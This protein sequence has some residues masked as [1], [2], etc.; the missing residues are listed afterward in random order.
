MMHLSLFFLL[1]FPTIGKTKHTHLLLN[2]SQLPTSY[3]MLFPLDVV[4]T[5]QALIP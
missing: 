5:K 3:Q 2:T 4:V 1:S